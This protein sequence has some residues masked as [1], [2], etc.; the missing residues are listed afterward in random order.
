MA[1]ALLLRDAAFGAGP[2][3]RRRSQTQRD[4]YRS[5]LSYRSVGCSEQ[6]G[7]H[8]SSA[9]EPAGAKWRGV[10]TLK[11][12]FTSPRLRCRNGIGPG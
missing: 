9:N 4:R 11:S 12:Y 8:A 2:P 10:Q 1:R 3:L 5:L 7:G 6:D